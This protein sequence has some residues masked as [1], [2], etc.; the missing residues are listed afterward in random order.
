MDFDFRDLFV[1]SIGSI[2]TL[3]VFVAKWLAERATRVR[4]NATDE[5]NFMEN[6]KQRLDKLTNEYIAKYDENVKITQAKS[7][8]EVTLQVKDGIIAEFLR[9]RQEFTERIMRLERLVADYQIVER[10]HKKEI[11][12]LR[13]KIEILEGAQPRQSNA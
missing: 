11:A 8:L 1:A 7:A 12:E 13:L 3:L 4:T 6:A 5:L 2:T 9:E 10:E